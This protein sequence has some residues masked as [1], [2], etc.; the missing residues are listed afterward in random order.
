MSYDAAWPIA[1]E[2]YGSMMSEEIREF[3]ARYSSLFQWF[4]DRLCEAPVTLTHG[5]WRG[6]NL[7]FTGDPTRPL[8][9]VDWQLISV[10]KGIKD[11]TYF[12][13]QSLRP[14][15][16]AA[17]EQGLLRIWLDELHA[18]GVGGYEFDQA[19][20]DYRL[21]VAWAFVYPVIATSAL[22]SADERGIEL[23]RSMLE[24]C[25]AAIEG[26]DALAVLPS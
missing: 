26:V 8:I 6:D 17:H 24:R 22:D 10:A 1:L 5:D 18:D 3:G 23:T 12:V 14:E 2:A 11:F 20:D 4:C 13:T 25:I 21:S 15:D 9:A 16:R 7:F 19:W